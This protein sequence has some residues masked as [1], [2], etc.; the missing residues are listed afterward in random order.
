MRTLDIDKLETA[1]DSEWCARAMSGSEPWVTLGRSFE[2]SLQIITDPSKEVYLS[3]VEGDAAGFIILNMKGA[4][5][6]YIQT[7]C[8]APEFRGH[9]IGSRLLQ[10]AEDRIFAVCPNVFLCVS[11]FNEGARRLY[12]RAGYETIGELR[13]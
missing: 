8:I 6:G 10:F 11:S 3:S 7:I 12:E 13:D 1:S 2:E 5:V 4:F 9:G